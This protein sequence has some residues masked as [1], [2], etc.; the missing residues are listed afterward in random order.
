M[1]SGDTGPLHLAAAVGTPVVALFGPTNPARNGPWSPQDGIVSKYHICECHYRRRCSA[2]TWC[3]E[4]ISVSEVVDAVGRRL[5][6]PVRAAIAGSS[7]L[8]C[9]AD[10]F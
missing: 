5:T 10:S 4:Q 2:R 3:L 8:E 6:P 1:I 9:S 7:A